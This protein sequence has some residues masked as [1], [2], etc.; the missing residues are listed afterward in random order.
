MKSSC[1]NAYHR[2][3]LLLYLDRCDAPAACRRPARG[4][5][6]NVGPDRSTSRQ[7]CIN[8]LH[9]IPTDENKRCTQG[10][11]RVSKGLAGDRKSA[12]PVHVC[13]WRRS[14]L[15][16]SH[17]H[18]ACLSAT[19]KIVVASPIRLS[20]CA[21]LLGCCRKPVG[22]APSAALLAL[23]AASCASTVLLY[24]VPCRAWL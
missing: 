5:R 14:G 24:T 13:A 16:N 17:H 21:V 6:P 23:L 10:R 15:S 19:T 8:K 12:V 11:V 3:W 20:T 9:T 7:C 22:P 18:V 1:K 4:G 2:L